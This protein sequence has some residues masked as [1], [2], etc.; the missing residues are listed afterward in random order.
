MGIYLSRPLYDP[1]FYWHL[2]TGQWIWQNMALP[3]LDPFGVPPLPPPSPRTEFILTSYWLLQLILYAFYS[4]SGMWGI[5][6]FR[7]IIA[8]F[9]LLVCIRWTNVR[10]NS[11]RAVMVL[12]TVLLL[13]YYFI[14]RPQFISFVSF[15]ILLVILFRFLEQR[16]TRSLWSTL[17][18]LSLLMIL[19]SNMH[20]GFLIG[21][22]ILIYCVIAEGMKFFHGSLAPMPLRDYRILFISSVTALGASFVNPNALNLIKYLPII[23]DS[24]YYVNTNNLEE[25][26]LLAYFRETTDY[27]VFFY[28][29]SIALTFAA[30]VLSEHRKNI[31]WAGI[32]AGTAFMGCQHMRL[33]PFFLVSAMLFLT[34]FVETEN[35]AVKGRLILYSMLAVTTVYCVRDEFPRIFEATRSGL[36]PVQQFPVK[37]ADFIASNN[38]NGNI[39]TNMLWG[40]YMIWRAGP[41]NK[42]FYDGRSLSIQR[43]QEYDQSRIIALNQRSYW[44]G[45]FDEYNIRVAVLPIY[46]VD[47]TPDLLTQS[48]YSD[49]E[50]TLVFADERDAVFVREVYAEQPSSLSHK[51]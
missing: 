38:I 30:L 39:Y 3:H 34:K 26:S 25:F 32:L 51:N 2:K 44:K 49:K 14:E 27:A 12:G 11:V 18:P 29:A 8:G 48:I 42:I 10:L 40:G 16:A 43:A 1:D 15:G 47:G 7:W 9:F 31:T 5:I 4:L 50:W 46:E 45:L 35:F 36:V 20:G 19:W 37:A 21:Q 24:S 13:E 41:E 17:V 6:L 23:F 28:G 33:M 22:S